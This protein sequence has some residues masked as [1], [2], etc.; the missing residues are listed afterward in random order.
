MEMARNRRDD[1]LAVPLEGGEGRGKAFEKGMV[2]AIGGEKGLGDADGCAEVGADL[3][4]EG[5]G[6]QLV[7]EADA[8]AGSVSCQDFL[9]AFFLS[10]QKGVAFLLVDIGAAAQN[11]KAVIVVRV[12]ENSLPG[13]YDVK[14]NV[15]ALGCLL[16][17]TTRSFPWA[18]L[19]DCQFLGHGVRLELCRVSAGFQ[20]QVAGREEEEGVEVNKGAGLRESVVPPVQG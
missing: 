2:A 1:G 11:E 4:A 3:G 13:L 12:R 6:Q 17:K 20:G 15:V 10:H 16:K 9:E 8:Q 5:L 18:V 14:F 7:A 19:E